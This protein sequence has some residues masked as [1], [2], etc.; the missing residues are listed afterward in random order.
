MTL[1]C[2]TPMATAGPVYS[3]DYTY[4]VACGHMTKKEISMVK[5]NGTQCAS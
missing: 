1:T 3:N 5:L 2:F 4:G